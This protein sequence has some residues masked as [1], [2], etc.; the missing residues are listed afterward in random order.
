MLFLVIRNSSN[1]R[2]IGTAA[3]INF[4][5]PNAALILGRCLFGGG[6]YSSKYGNDYVS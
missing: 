6:A 5:V 4:S 3:L 1:K 2:C